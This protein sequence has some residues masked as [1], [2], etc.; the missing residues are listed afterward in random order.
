MSGDYYDGARALQ[1]DLVGFMQDIVR[2]PSLSCEEGAVVARIRDEMLK[3]GFDEVTVD[4]MGNVIGRIG[5]GPRVIALDGHV[6]TVDIGD[7]S[8]WER[9]PMAADI[10]DGVLLD[11][12]LEQARGFDKL[13]DC[14]D[15]VIGGSS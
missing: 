12:D 7:R 11:L 9:D 2:I 8:Q 1:D 4:P 3:L 14:L 5:S 6:D 15:T 13:N 10:V